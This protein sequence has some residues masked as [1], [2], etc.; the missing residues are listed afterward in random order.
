M[1]SPSIVT[2][3]KLSQVREEIVERHA[4][5]EPIGAILRALKVKFKEYKKWL[6]SIEEFQLDM[7]A[8]QEAHI[9]ARLAALDAA[10]DQFPNPQAAKVYSDNLRWQ[11]SK[12]APERFGDRLALDHRHTLDLTGAFGRA[13]ERIQSPAGTRPI[14]IDAQARTVPALSAPAAPDSVSDALTLDPAPRDA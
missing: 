14:T 11:L 8:A 10:L 2:V 1:P 3:L 4:A 5:G 9:E 6:S 12:L 13:L 7:E